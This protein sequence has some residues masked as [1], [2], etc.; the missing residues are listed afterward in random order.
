MYL[1]RAGVSKREDILRQFSDELNFVIQSSQVIQTQEN[2]TMIEALISK[3]VNWE[4]V[5]YLAGRHKVYPTVYRTLRGVEHPSLPNVVMEDFYKKTRKT[6]LEAVFMSAE[7]IRVIRDMDKF[8]INPV[9]LKGYAMAM[10]LYGDF[11]IRPNRDLDLF[12]K[13]EDVKVAKR[14]IEE[15]GFRLISPT[16]EVTPARLKNWIDM[17]HHLE[18]WHREKKILLELHW[19]IGQAGKEIPTEVI[20]RNLSAV[21]LSGNVVTALREEVLFV[22]LAMH[23]ASHG[24]SELRWIE[25]IVLL[26]A[27]KNFSW[28]IVFA[29][30][31]RLGVSSLVNQA[32]LLAYWTSGVNIDEGIQQQCNADKHGQKLAQM[33][34]Y[35]LSAT[36]GNPQIGSIYSLLY[37][38][39]RL[40]ELALQTSWKQKLRL[41]GNS[42]KPVEEDIKFVSLPDKL[43]ALYY[44]I[45]PFSWAKRRIGQKFK[46]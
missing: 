41:L 38:R 22:Y 3:G 13:P 37:Y 40:Y 15:K 2:K 29:V 25:D 32:I 26:L 6:A 17:H 19:R 8:G 7:L 42:I 11:T 9:V 24:W 30:A 1:G 46:D 12:V 33:A 14:V 35:F 4:H 16:F 20:I 36:Y 39:W 43:Y 34:L 45:R 21:S 27:R 5:L 18:Y 23:G 10:Q 28:P 31:D 44:I